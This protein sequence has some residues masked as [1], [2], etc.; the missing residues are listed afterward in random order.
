METKIP[1]YSGSYFAH[2]TASSFQEWELLSDHLREVSALAAQFAAKFGAAHLGAIAGLLHD[3]GKYSLPFQQRLRDS[4]TYAPHAT[5]GAQLAEMEYGRL[6]GRMLAYVIAGHHGG[7]AN[8]LTEDGSFRTPLKERL[9]IPPGRDCPDY[10]AF[11]DEIRLPPAPALPKP[12]LYPDPA[13]AGKYACIGLSLFVRMLFSALVDADRLCTEAFY[14]RTEDRKRGDLRQHWAKLAD[15]KPALDNALAQTAAKAKPTAVNARRAEVLAAARANALLPQGIFTL[16]VPTGGGKTLS[17][18]AFALD[19]ALKHGLDRIIYVIP[20]TSIIEQTAGVFRDVFDGHEAVLEHHSAFDEEAFLRKSE[21]QGGGEGTGRIADKLRLAAE[22]WDAPIVV[23]TAVQFFESLF[24]ATPGKCRKLHNIAKSVVILDEAQTLPL[25]LLRPCVAALD[26]LAR[27]Y[28]TTI[29]LCTATQPALVVH[30]GADAA[31]SFKGGFHGVREIVPEP[32]QLYT[33][34]R[35]VRVVH[36]GERDNDWLVAQL[37]AQEQG[38]CILNTRLH[39]REV[40]QRLEGVEGRV[41]L[42]A[43]MCP[44][45]RT[46]RLL[47]IRQRLKEGRP[48]RLVATSLIEAG[49][50]VDFPAVYRA[51]TGLDA[52]AQAAGRCNREGRRGRDESMVFVFRPAGGQMHRAMKQLAGIAESVLRRHSDDPLSLQAVED[53]F[54]ELYWLKSVGRDDELDRDGLTRLNAGLAK[55]WFPFESVARLFKIIEDGMK[56]VLIPFDGD[57]KRLIG[58]LK[59]A[60]DVG[61]IARKLQPYIVNVPPRAFLAL[62]QA[63]AVQPVNE[64]RFGEQFCVLVSK[65]LYRDDVGLL[66]DDPTFLDIESTII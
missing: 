46:Q 17:S 65:E 3:I 37:A 62:R 39:A 12:R 66:W 20:F 24:A 58:E 54:R 11:A 47:E 15:L 57:A 36:V 51:E 52:V 43:L 59:D 30:E 4:K 28:R 40:Y 32:E 44:R 16:T 1:E 7:L 25:P 42:S 63:G 29:V 45:H 2:S 9:T 48:C 53:Y 56:P 14:D 27:N 61:Q 19:H 64:P 26:E 55:G 8:G 34:M 23:T 38:L 35:R 50:D 33:D 18:L 21:A 5:A 60:D 49:V 13:F 41:H 10:S 6:L 31:R 22:N